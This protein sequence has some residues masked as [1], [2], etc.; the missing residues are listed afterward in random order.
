MNLLLDFLL[1]FIFLFL[2]NTV[3]KLDYFTVDLN[4][5]QEVYKIFF[6]AVFDAETKHFKTNAQLGLAY[7]NFILEAIRH[8]YA[9]LEFVVKNTP[10]PILAR[11][12]G[13]CGIYLFQT[14]FCTVCRGENEL[15]CV[16]VCV[17]VWKR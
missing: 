14:N 13:L 15:F 4:K 2:V 1:G 6:T 3:I 7:N 12:A 5:I 8:V 11:V 16:Y 17:C 10:I 9:V